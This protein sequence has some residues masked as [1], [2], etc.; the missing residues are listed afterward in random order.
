LFEKYHAKGMLHYFEYDP[1]HPDESDPANHPLIFLAD[2]Q[3]IGTIRIDIKHDGRAIFRLVAIDEPWQGHGLGSVMLDMAEDFA[4]DCGAETICLN[5]VPD[6]YRFYTRHGYA[7][8]RWVGCTGNPTEIPVVKHLAAPAMPIIAI[9][10]A[11]AAVMQ[12]AA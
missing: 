7:P 6:A 8:D 1:V 10:V 2:G 3:I 12:V 5:A 9:P 4:H 11:A